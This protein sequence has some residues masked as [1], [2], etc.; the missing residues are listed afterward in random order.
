MTISEEKRKTAEA[1]FMLINASVEIITPIFASQI[2]HVNKL[3]D[4]GNMDALK[5]RHPVLTDDFREYSALLT[6]LSAL[7]TALSR[8]ENAKAP[9]SYLSDFSAAAKVAN[10]AIEFFDTRAKSKSDDNPK[11]DTG[12]SSLRELAKK[13]ADIIMKIDDRRAKGGDDDKVVKIG[14]FAEGTSVHEFIMGSNAV[15]GAA[16]RN[17]K[18][19]HI[20]KDLISRSFGIYG[21]AEEYGKNVVA[22]TVRSMYPSKKLTP[23]ELSKLGNADLVDYFRK[24][25]NVDEVLREQSHAVRESGALQKLHEYLAKHYKQYLNKDI[26]TARL[27][28]IPHEPDAADVAM[29][30]EAADTLLSEIDKEILTQYVGDSINAAKTDMRSAI[31]RMRAYERESG[32][33]V[34]VVMKRKIRDATKALRIA[35][36]E[37][38][39]ARE[40]TNM[41]ASKSGIITDVGSAVERLTEFN[42][43]IKNSLTAEETMYAQVSTRLQE[44]MQAWMDFISPERV[45]TCIRRVINYVAFPKILT[46]VT[47]SDISTDE[48]SALRKKFA[49]DPNDIQDI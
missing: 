26:D 49:I 2:S 46:H 48:L 40:E 45:D 41:T 31:A 4:M 43:A 38:D 14:G 7:S 33:P 21:G 28:D 24:L 32:P 16:S 42:N 6:S 13:I 3:I 11:S 36:N 15:N 10:H 12:V 8:M 22:R 20:R 39:A 25:D 9:E 19:H 18:L 47:D 5:K 27:P 17:R 35:I 23:S 34:R 1:V 30:S 37:M 29:F 44:L